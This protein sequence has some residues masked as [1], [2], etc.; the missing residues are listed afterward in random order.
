MDN[1]K[2]YYYIKVHIR[3]LWEFKVQQSIL[4]ICKKPQLQSILNYQLARFKKKINS[5][6]VCTPYTV[7]AE[8]PH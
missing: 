7:F 6:I 4:I 5:A 8:L 3:I 2:N 1:K